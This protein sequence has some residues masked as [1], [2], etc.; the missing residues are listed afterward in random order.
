MLP[1]SAHGTTYPGRREVNQDDILQYYPHPDAFFLAVADGMGGT[2]GGQIAS[3]AVLE[4]VETYLD[5]RFQYQTDPG[6]LKEILSELYEEAQEAIRD[7]I[8]REPSLDA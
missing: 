8:D 1:I 7:V 5:E 2:A 6:D 4:R 3:Q